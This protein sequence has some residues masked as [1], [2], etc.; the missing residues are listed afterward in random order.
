MASFTTPGSMLTLDLTVKQYAYLYCR[1]GR[2]VATALTRA[3]YISIRRQMNTTLNGFPANP[4]D[5]IS[6]TAAVNATTVSSGGAAAATTMVL[7]SGT[8]FAAQQICCAQLAAARCEFF[9]IDDLTSATITI[10]RGSGFLVTHNASD[11]VTNG[12]DCGAILLPGGA[13]YE[14]T[15]INNSGQTVVMAIDAEVHASDTAV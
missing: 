6:S 11:V 15:P 10:D 13:V 12:A 14:I 1:I 3:A 5:F 2:N 8:G 7:A 9:G 4:Y